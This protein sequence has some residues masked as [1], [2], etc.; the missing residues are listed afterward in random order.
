M[1][2]KQHETQVI[3]KSAQHG[4]VITQDMR[5]RQ[6]QVDTFARYH[7]AMMVPR[8][9]RSIEEQLLEQCGKLEFARDAYYRK[10]TSSGREVEVLSGTFAEVAQRLIRNVSVDTSPE[11]EDEWSCHYRTTLIDLESNIPASETFKVDKVVERR[12]LRPSD[13]VVS[14]HTSGDG[15]TIYLVRATEEQLESKLRAQS[16]KTKRLLLLGL[17]PADVR[18]RCLERCKQVV[19][20]EDSRDLP[21][22]FKGIAAAF[23]ALGVE[24]SDLKEYLGKP[25]ASATL[26]QLLELRSVL[27][28]IRDG[29]ATWRKALEDKTEKQAEAQPRNEAP[30][31]KGKERDEKRGKDK[32]TPGPAPAPVQRRGRRSSATPDPGGAATAPDSSSSPTTSAPESTEQPKPRA[33]RRGDDD[34]DLQPDSSF[35]SATA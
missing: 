5:M 7:L 12:R 27:A 22:A 15:E 4:L 33:S 10:P 23:G 20:K 2:P 29:E 14:Q 35:N 24:M 13:S 16:A 3:H 18:A 21:A 30:V 26:D 17:V 34:E 9:W 25:P 8:D 11:M 1:A 32:P 31:S 6:A 19:S 28:L